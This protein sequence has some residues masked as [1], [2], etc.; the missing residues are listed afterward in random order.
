[1]GQKNLFLQADI[2]KSA[3]GSHVADAELRNL[4]NF[5]IRFLRRGNQPVLGILIQKNGDL[6]SHFLSLRKLSYGK[7]YTLFPLI[8]YENTKIP[9]SQ[10][11]TFLGFS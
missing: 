4:S 7:Q 5:H 6:I 2:Q 10:N 9:F 1:M 3:D 11:L 8:S